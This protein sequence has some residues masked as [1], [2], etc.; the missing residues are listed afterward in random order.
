MSAGNLQTCCHVVN[1]LLFGVADI[2]RRANVHSWH[3]N[4]WWLIIVY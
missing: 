2:Y 1:I 3:C 4:H